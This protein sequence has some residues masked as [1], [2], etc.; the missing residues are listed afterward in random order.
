[1]QITEAKGIS[2]RKIGRQGLA[3]SIGAYL[4]RFHLQ[5]ETESPKHHILNNRQDD[6]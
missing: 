1:M 5:T 6:G 2:K 3:L 4:S